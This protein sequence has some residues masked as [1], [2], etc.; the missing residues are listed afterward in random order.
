MATTTL[1]PSSIDPSNNPGSIQV[2]FRS[3]GAPNRIPACV[4]V[5]PR[6]SS[7]KTAPVHDRRQG[8]GGHFRAAPPHRSSTRSRAS[9]A[10][11]RA[12]P[13]SPERRIRPRLGAGGGLGCHN[14]TTVAANVAIGPPVSLWG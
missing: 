9:Y 2:I 11:A 6:H 13:R 5:H 4:V 1:I 3:S 8:S 12:A 10:L 7:S 14:I